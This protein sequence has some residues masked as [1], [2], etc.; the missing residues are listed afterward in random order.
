VRAYEKLGEKDKADQLKAS[1]LKELR[2]PN[3][4]IDGS[5]HVSYFVMTN[6]A[7]SA[8]YYLNYAIDRRGAIIYNL[9]L[10]CSYLLRPFHNDPRWEPTL[11]RI[12]AQKCDIR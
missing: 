6:N 4:D 11:K 10:P 7:D 8:F 9:G 12:R 5:G 1:V 2:K 3:A